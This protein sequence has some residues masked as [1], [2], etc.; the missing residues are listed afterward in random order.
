L[1]I[2]IIVAACLAG[3]R[4]Q[5]A[6]NEARAIVGLEQSG[7]SSANPDQKLFFDF[8]I[9]RELN[10]SSLSLWG[11]VQLASYP[12]QITTPLAQ[13]NLAVS[14]A[15]LP[16]N[17]LVNSEAFATGLD[18]HPFR[19]WIAGAAKR[20]FGLIVGVGATG[21]FPPAS[22]LTLFAVP[23][24]SS[25]QYASFIAQFPQAAS[26]AYVGFL[27]PDRAQFYRSWFTGFRL[28]TTSPQNSPATYTV[29]IGQDEQITG[30]NF[31]GAVA[32]FDVFYP[33]PV[34]LSGYTCLYLFGAANMKLATTLNTTPFLLAAAPSTITG[35]EPS[36]AIVAVPSA[37]DLYRIGFGVDAVGLLC[38]IFH[39]KCN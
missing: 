33:L 9:D 5:S 11:E 31:S 28:T 8:F 32:K 10:V 38:A 23:S 18:W 22:R 35:S 12:Q 20:R 6:T 39:G 3:L 37:R 25:P 27:P 34:K 14:V 15:A 4:A 21:P 29:S 17:K 13:F 16:V 26:S 24:P 2:L 36:V 1:K 7:A 30:G 19:P